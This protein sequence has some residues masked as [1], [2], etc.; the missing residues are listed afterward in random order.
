MTIYNTEDDS[1]FLPSCFKKIPPEFHH[2]TSLEPKWDPKLKE[3]LDK[4][5]ME[6]FKVARAIV[7]SV[8]DCHEEPEF[9][10]LKDEI[11][12]EFDNYKMD[13]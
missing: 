3:Q 1:G 2:A 4:S 8:L 11:E 5:F 10:E 7:E 6:G 9:D 13:S 12:D